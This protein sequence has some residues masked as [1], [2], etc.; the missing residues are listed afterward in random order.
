MFL[1]EESE[2]EESKVLYSLNILNILN[3]LFLLYNSW[4][5]NEFKLRIKYLADKTIVH[6]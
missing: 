5:F 4:H 3:I 6:I 1:S 2:F